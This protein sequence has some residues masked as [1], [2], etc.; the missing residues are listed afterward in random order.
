MCRKQKKRREVKKSEKV[1]AVER[2][3]RRRLQLHQH[4][5]GENEINLSLIFENIKHELYTAQ[6][7]RSY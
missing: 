3:G 5:E 2:V 6:Y 7:Q 1:W 4:M